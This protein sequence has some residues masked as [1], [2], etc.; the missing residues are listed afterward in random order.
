M[1]TVYVEDHITHQKV[2]VGDMLSRP[3][4]S[5]LIRIISQFSACTVYA[6][7]SNYVR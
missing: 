1:F 5:Q 2:V 3:E 6:V 4:A 7:Q